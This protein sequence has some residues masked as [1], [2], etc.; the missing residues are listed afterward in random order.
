MKSS[1][2]STARE[3]ED[4]FRLLKCRVKIDEDP[5][6]IGIKFII[7]VPKEHYHFVRWIMLREMPMGILYDLQLLNFFECRILKYQ[8]NFKEFR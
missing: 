7:K 1:I 8:F 5:K 3:M 2:V 4:F 6:S